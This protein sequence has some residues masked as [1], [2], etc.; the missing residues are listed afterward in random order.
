MD[1]T[2]AEVAEDSELK[3]ETGSPSPSSGECRD[4]SGAR[5]SEDQPIVEVKGRDKR[6]SWEREASGYCRERTNVR[7]RSCL[8]TA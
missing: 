5:R 1:R 7:I 2:M 3:C 6:A 8:G 4:R